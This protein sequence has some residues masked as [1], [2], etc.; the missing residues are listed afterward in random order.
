MFQKIRM[1][2]NTNTPEQRPKDSQAKPD[3]L[4]EHSDLSKK[5][6]LSEEEEEVLPVETREETLGDLP[7]LKIQTT[8][9][10]LKLLDQ[11][12]ELTS[13]G[14]SENYE[15]EKPLAS[16]EPPRN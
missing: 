7:I 11:T 15:S 1:Q 14:P 8:L 13:E 6:D 3:A 2:N 12:P 10:N 9:V 4:R 16:M 5:E